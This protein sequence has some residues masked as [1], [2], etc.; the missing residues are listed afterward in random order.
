MS[1]RCQRNDLDY[2]HYAHQIS[3]SELKAG[4]V[5]LNIDEHV[6]IFNAW[7]DA[8]Q[9]QYCAYEQTPPQTIYHVVAYPYWPG[10]GTYLPYRLN[11]I[12]Q[13]QSDNATN[14]TNNGSNG[15]TVDEEKGYLCG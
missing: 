2:P 15:Y 10:Y 14:G 8:G 6:L 12:S 5:L 11:G 4:D 13:M 3:K 9:T 7:A 1:V